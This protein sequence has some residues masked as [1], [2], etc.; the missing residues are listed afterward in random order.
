MPVLR[1]LETMY[2]CCQGIAARI[3]LIRSDGYDY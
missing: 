1:I 2:D 3:V